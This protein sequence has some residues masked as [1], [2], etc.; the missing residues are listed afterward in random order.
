M[1]HLNHA[2]FSIILTVTPGIEA[3]FF[4]TQQTGWS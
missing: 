1:L 4:A 2:R 3:I